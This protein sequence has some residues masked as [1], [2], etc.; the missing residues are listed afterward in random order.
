MRTAPIP[1]ACGAKIKQMTRAWF[2]IAKSRK[3][4]HAG[5]DERVGTLARVRIRFT[6]EFAFLDDLCV[7][8]INNRVRP[9]VFPRVSV[10]PH[11]VLD[12]VAVRPVNVE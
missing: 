7:V 9:F 3:E 1:M 8:G 5:A 12:V 11:P 10:I 6:C 4:E 2:S